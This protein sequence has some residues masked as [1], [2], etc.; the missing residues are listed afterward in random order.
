MIMDPYCKR[1]VK[2]RTS[3]YIINQIYNLL[4]TPLSDRH[5][6]DTECSQKKGYW[7]VIGNA[8][9]NGQAEEVDKLFNSGKILDL[10]GHVMKLFS[11]MEVQEYLLAT[12]KQKNDDHKRKMMILFKCEV[13]ESDWEEVKKS[14][15]ESVVKAEKNAREYSGHLKFNKPKRLNVHTEIKVDMVTKNM[16]NKRSGGSYTTTM[17][18]FLMTCKNICKAPEM[19]LKWV[20]PGYTRAVM[21]KVKTQEELQEERISFSSRNAKSWS[22]LGSKHRPDS[23]D[24][25]IAEETA[26]KKGKP[27]GKGKLKGKGKTSGKSSNKKRKHKEQADEQALDEAEELENND[28]QD[29]GGAAE[30]ES[31]SAASSSSGSHSISTPNQQPGHAATFIQAKTN[32]SVT[33]T[34]AQRKQPPAQ[35]LD[36]S[37]ALLQRLESVELDLK[38]K[39][40]LTQCRQEVQKGFAEFE[41]V[42]EKLSLKISEICSQLMEESDK[43]KIL[44]AE[45]EESVTSDAEIKEI[46]Q[47]HAYLGLDEAKLKLLVTQVLKTRGLTKALR[48]KD[49]RQFSATM[50]TAVNKTT[51]AYAKVETDV[52]ALAIQAGVGFT[53]TTPLMVTPVQPSGTSAIAAG[54]REVDLTEENSEGINMQGKAVNVLQELMEVSESGDGGIIVASNQRLLS[55]HA[56]SKEN[57]V[58]SGVADAG[59]EDSPAASVKNLMILTQSQPKKQ[60]QFLNGELQSDNALVTVRKIMVNADTLPAK[61]PLMTN[62]Y[63]RT[64]VPDE[65][66]DQQI[67]RG[68]DSQDAQQKNLKQLLAVNFMSTMVSSPGLKPRPADLSKWKV[69]E[70]TAWLKAECLSTTGLKQILIDRIVS[71]T[72]PLTSGQDAAL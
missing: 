9:F 32:K 49:H 17:A 25:K 47:A 14:V 39:I 38:N 4:K 15:V 68:R 44:A 22:A 57:S 20:L 26:A 52:K 71:N 29:F 16:T 54:L 42:M 50:D 63:E 62:T 6:L 72:L 59:Q 34:T 10:D 69:I 33:F 31:S 24:P 35:A 13:P 19:V 37:V 48:A 18:F 11:D 66:A 23:T 45:L 55:A 46:K 58:S 27:K 8:Y 60:R 67:Q 21:L 51:Q 1:A 61:G 7:L 3:D 53:V 40:S 70:L 41:K 65:T 5:F 30:E 2:E 12:E 56:V 64:A 28:H 43:S 36:M